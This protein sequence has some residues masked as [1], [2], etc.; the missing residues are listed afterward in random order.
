MSA[1]VTDTNLWIDLH[2]GG[3]VDFVLEN[4]SDLC[5]TDIVLHELRREPSADHLVAGGVRALGLDGDQVAEVYALVAA[6]PRLSGQDAS[7]LVAARATGSVL[8]TGDGHLRKVAEGLGVEVHGSLWMLEH[9]VE[10]HDLDP[11]VALAA[12]DAMV[13]GGSRFP[14]GEVTALRRRLKRT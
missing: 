12:L 4:V 6:Q 10:E 2:C 14:E 5:A 1:L 11:E 7:A 8:V 3:L 13:S 9:L